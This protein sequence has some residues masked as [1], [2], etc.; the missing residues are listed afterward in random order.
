MHLVTSYIATLFEV[1]FRNV[2]YSLYAVPSM[3]SIIQHFKDVTIPNFSS[4][5]S[6][7]S[8]HNAVKYITESVFQHFHL[9]QFL[10][11]Q[12]Q[13][14]DTT[15]LERAVETLVEDPL[16]LSEGIIEETW[17]KTKKKNDLE[18][19]YDRRVKELE[20]AGTKE[21]ELADANLQH[22][23]ET[24]LTNF[25]NGP[26]K[27][28][29]EDLSGI[30]D[31]LMKA[32]IE[33]AQVMISQHLLKKNLDFSLKLDQLE[34]FLPPSMKARAESA[35]KSKSPATGKKSKS[36]ATGKKS[37]SPATGKKPKSPATGKM[38]KSP[39]IGKTLKV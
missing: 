21:T 32:H 14:T 2:T 8:L 13:V 18:A 6:P 17:I 12:P 7:S 34:L 27:V 37:K 22:L 16:D 4:H 30:V 19:E 10:L 38:S 20:V 28:S 36:P 24:L 11:T 35:K 3:L 39:A 31:T 15:T 26:Q 23:Y 29:P 1:I 33:S 25:T 9:Y 5:L